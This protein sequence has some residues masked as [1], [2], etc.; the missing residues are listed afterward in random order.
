MSPDPIKQTLT[1]FSQKTSICIILVYYQVS[2]LI[3][4]LSISAKAFPL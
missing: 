4:L 1:S 2:H 3:L